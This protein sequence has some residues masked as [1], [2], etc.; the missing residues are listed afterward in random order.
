M[1]QGSPAHKQTNK[2]LSPSPGHR[3][4]HSTMLEMPGSELTC[5]A[6]EP[7]LGAARRQQRMGMGQETASYLIFFGHKHLVL[8]SCSETALLL[9]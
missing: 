3:R 6:R 5:R 2:K 4:A 8:K 9:E 1:L 7:R